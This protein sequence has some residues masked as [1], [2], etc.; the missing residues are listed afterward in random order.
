MKRMG[1]TLDEI[2]M[3]KLLTLNT[4]IA[5]VTVSAGDVLVIRVQCNVMAVPAAICP[6]FNDGWFRDR[7][8]RFFPA[9][10]TEKKEYAEKKS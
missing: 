4:I 1:W 8:F 3:D 5:I 9:A 10:G 7:C 2:L 6:V